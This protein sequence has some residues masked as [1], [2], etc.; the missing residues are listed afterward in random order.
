MTAPTIG[1]LALQ[2]DVREHLATLTRLGVKT[3]PVRRQ[4][5][6]D[7][8]DGLVL[9]GG[10]STTMWRLARTF[11]LLEPLRARVADKMPVFGTCA[12]MVLLAE[13]LLDGAEGQETIGGLDIT[14]RRN[15]FGRQTESFET[16]LSVAGVEDT[17]RAVFIRAPWVEA[18]GT[19][20]EVLASVSGHPVAVRHGHLLA[21]SFHPEVNGEDRLHRLF[22]DTCW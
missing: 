10:E 7:T 8:C 20:V 11:E 17:V 4:A 15:A 3:L 16:D 14:V 19:E 1:V 21:T 18:T 6:L 13:R 9:P 22:L 12:G 5:E 2:G